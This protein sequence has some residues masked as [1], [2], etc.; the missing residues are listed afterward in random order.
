M[1]LSSE[2]GSAMMEFVLSL[3]FLWLIIA[4][5][6][7]FGAGVLSRHRVA[8]IVREHG[9]TDAAN[10]SMTEREAELLRAM[11]FSGAYSVEHTGSGLEGDGDF[12]FVR[13]L[14]AKASNAHKLCFEGSR[15]P[16]V[17]VL[18]EIAVSACFEVD[19]NFWT[20]EETKD[21]RN[22]MMGAALAGAIIGSLVMF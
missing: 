5:S 22:A 2:R 21:E 6:L 12:D 3:P 8:V 9:F 14:L 16:I 7:G 15:R 17:N 13:R 1:R 10:A 11:R 18:P 20:Y 19:S 4:L